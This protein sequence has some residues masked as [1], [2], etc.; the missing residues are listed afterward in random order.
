MLVLLLSQ[1]GHNENLF[2]DHAIFQPE[3][4][5]AM[6]QEDLKNNSRKLMHFGGGA[7]QCPGMQLSLIETKYTLIQLYNQFVFCN[8]TD[9]SPAHDHFAFTV[10]PKNLRVIIRKR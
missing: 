5:L 10:A 3:R 1:S 8:A 7:R 2:I 6:A 9:S 4:W